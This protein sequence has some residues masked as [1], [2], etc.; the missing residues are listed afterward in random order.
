MFGK[1]KKI[2][3]SVEMELL[4][5]SPRVEWEEDE[6]AAGAEVMRKLFGNWKKK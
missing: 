6:E 2:E 4:E 3:E 5:K 1:K